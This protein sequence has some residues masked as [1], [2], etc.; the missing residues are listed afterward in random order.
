M[1]VCNPL[2]SICAYVA[3]LCAHVCSLVSL[4]IRLKC[5]QARYTT[6][7][8]ILRPVLAHPATHLTVICWLRSLH[9]TIW[10]LHWQNSAPSTFYILETC[11]PFILCRAAAISTSS[12]TSFFRLWLLFRLFHK[13][14]YTWSTYK[15]MH[16]HICRYIM[17]YVYK[18]SSESW[19]FTYL[20]E[21][22]EEKKNVIS[23]NECRK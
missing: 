9:I 3:W 2:A 21:E 13:Y 1:C 12:S 17:L 14:N 11:K 10:A 4:I 7:Q 18:Y 5:C 22:E 6:L 20:Q 23:V 8:I 16:T 19:F 15:Y